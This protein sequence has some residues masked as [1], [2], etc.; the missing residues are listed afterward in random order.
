MEMESDHLVEEMPARL[1]SGE[2][3]PA[4]LFVSFEGVEGCGKSTQVRRLARRLEAYGREVVLTREPGGTE[5]GARLRSVLLGEFD[6][7]V[8]PVAEMMLYAADRAQHL[9][10]IVEPALG[11]GAVVLSDRFVDASLAYQGYGRRL[12]CS[13]ILDLHR[14][15]PLDRRPH[16][17][18]LLDL[19]PAVG[20]R[21]ARR[22]NDDR[23]VALS[24]GRFED[25]DLS[26]HE[27]VRDGYLLLAG[28]DPSR[29]RVLDATGDETVVEERVWSAVRDL[30]V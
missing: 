4:G 23:G 18:L 15:P 14:H 12:G 6:P 8:S 17:T 21:R 11:R 26:F 29:F 19:D 28:Q 24:E 1:R 10:E 9:T 25:E 2:D 22:R 3:P 27:R 20:L 7:P 13:L 30:V 16:R 5:I